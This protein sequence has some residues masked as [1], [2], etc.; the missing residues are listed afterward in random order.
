MK[1]LDGKLMLLRKN[2]KSPTGRAA[3][4][5]ANKIIQRTILII[6]VQS[7]ERDYRNTLSHVNGPL[8]LALAQMLTR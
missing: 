2:E 8:K 1:W 5:L 4:V 7:M 6:F 3:A